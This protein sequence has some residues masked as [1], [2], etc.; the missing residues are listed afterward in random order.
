MPTSKRR[1][2]RWNQFS[3]RTMFM[4]VTLVSISLAWV[5]H[6]RNWIAKRRSAID[7]MDL[8]LYLVEPQPAWRVWL[9]GDDSPLYA[10]RIHSKQFF[11]SYF[12][13]NDT[14]VNDERLV[15]FANLSELED[16]QLDCMSV[17]DDG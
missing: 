8:G 4:M 7:E 6:E 13:T 15:H 5:M 12:P 17:D 9:W 16:L 11:L 2:H 14:K 1:R 3:L 10:R